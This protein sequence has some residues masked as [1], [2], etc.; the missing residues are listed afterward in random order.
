MSVQTRPPD[1]KS[2]KT[3]ACLCFT[4]A[5]LDRLDRFAYTCDRSRSQV[6]EQ[7]ILSYLDTQCLEIVALKECPNDEL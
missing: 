6:V 3:R 1:K 5:T 4:Q 2:R 7:G